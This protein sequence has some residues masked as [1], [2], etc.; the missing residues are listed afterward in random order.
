MSAHRVVRAGQTYVPSRYR[1]VMHPSDL[2]AFADQ[3]AE[4]SNAL[5]D[6]ILVRARSQGYWLL[7][8][9]E[10]LLIP[11][12]RISQGDLEV[13]AEPPD[14]TL[15]ASAAAGLRPVELEGPRAPRA[16]IPGTGVVPDPV[17]LEPPPVLELSPSPPMP[18]P[19]VGGPPLEA[20]TPPTAEYVRAMRESAIVSAE[21]S[22]PPHDPAG[23]VVAPRAVEVPDAPPIEDMPEPVRPAPVRHD[24]D[25]PEP[26][27]PES[28]RPAPA[29]IPMAMAEPV[30]RDVSPEGLAVAADP[31]PA[32]PTVAIIEVRAP[33]G[34]IREVPFV[35]AVVTLG[36]GTSNDITIPDD[37]ISRHHGRFSARPGTLVYT[38]LGSTNGSMVGGVRVR[39]IALGVGDVVRVGRATLTIR[40]GP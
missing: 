20:A 18:E 19:S 31:A 27:L 23:A 24:T 21:P 28:V 37:R 12:A 35:G 40:P 4:L 7:A 16:P 26:V 3:A 17:A 10:V 13:D 6:A 32:P 1:V 30:L 34:T 5:A 25:R 29:D 15:V 33:D 38:A 36:R 8:R 11:S 9:P 22:V 39:E 14:P 2:A